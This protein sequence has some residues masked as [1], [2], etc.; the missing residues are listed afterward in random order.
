MNT[1]KHRV[2]YYY[3][4]EF[5]T[6]NYSTTHPMKPLRVAITDDLV[7]HYGLKKYMNC[8]VILSQYL[9]LRFCTNIYKESE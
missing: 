8:M 5:G 1:W 3:D 4:E 9:G 2:T 7:G 6:F